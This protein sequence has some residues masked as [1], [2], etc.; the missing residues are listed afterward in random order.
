MEFPSYVD[1]WVIKRTQ[2]TRYQCTL[3]TK[4]FDRHH[5]GLLGIQCRLRSRPHI[6]RIMQQEALFCT[7]CQLQCK[8]PS[9]YK[10]HTESKAHK[11]K[12]NPHLKP[13]LKCDAC[14]VKFRSFEEQKRHLVTK[15]H[16]K[17]LTQSPPLNLNTRCKVDSFCTL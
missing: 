16:Q 10:A 8:F 13:N 9:Q 7:I 4:G 2:E 15:K 12:E 1:S 5:G 3:C 11:Q 17:R 14:N 6:E